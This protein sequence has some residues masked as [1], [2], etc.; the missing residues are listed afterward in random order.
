MAFDQPAKRAAAWGVLVLLIGLLLWSLSGVLTP[1]IVAA[2]LAYALN[3]VV[4]RVD[5][6]A[7]G[8]MPRV[9]AVLL[10]ELGFIVLVLGLLLMLVPVLTRQLPL[11]QAQ[12][13]ALIDRASAALGPWLARL[14]VEEAA[15]SVDSV[16]AHLLDY[17]SSNGEGVLGSV[18]KSLRVGGNA[19][20][21]LAGNAVLIPVAL[22]YLLADWSRFTASIVG[23]VPL[24]LRQTF[25][26][27]MREADEVLG[28]YLRGQLLVML[29][30]AGYYSL[31]LALFGLSLALPIGVFTGLAVF[32]PYLGFGLGLVLATLSGLLQFGVLETLLMV[33]VVY[34]AGQLIESFFLTPRLVGER[35]GLHPLAV[36]FALMAFGQLLGFTGV[37]V[38]LPASAVVLVALRRARDRYLRSPLYRGAARVPEQR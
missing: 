19:A 24:P 30:L 31:G 29:V 33:G 9:A 7:K 26:S 28:Q 18:L 36:I 17:L 22:F 16:K 11:L 15:L 25:D 13:P 3:P 35:V 21:T 1:F 37:L 2:V 14:G 4:D 27:F 10:V 38:A 6:W 20:L 12:L 34:G 23:L 32:V 8:R 5:A